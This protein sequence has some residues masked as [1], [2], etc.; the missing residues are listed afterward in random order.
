M[1]IELITK[2]YEKHLY[3]RICGSE[4]SGFQRLRNRQAGDSC[5][6][7]H[8]DNNGGTARP[9]K[10]HD[11]AAHHDVLNVGNLLSGHWP[12]SEWSTA[13]AISAQSCLSEAFAGNSA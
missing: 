12:C 11:G 7:H 9:D 8:H 6:Q 10:Q 2:T 5:Y 4:P 3:P 1:F 13:S